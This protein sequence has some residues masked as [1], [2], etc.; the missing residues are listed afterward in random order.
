MRAHIG[1]A[2]TS[3]RALGIASAKNGLH[4]PVERLKRFHLPMLPSLRGLA[5]AG[6]DG[7]GG[8]VVV[9]GPGRVLTRVHV[10]AIFW[11]S[12][13]Y[14]RFRPGV[15]DICWAIE[16]IFLSP[17]MD[18]LSQYGV[19]NGW[20]DPNPIF[21]SMTIAAPNPFTEP[22]LRQLLGE[23]IDLPGS[24][25]SA[26]DWAGRLADLPTDPQMLPVVFTPYG[27]EFADADFNGFN[28]SMTRNGATFP[29][30]WV[31][32]DADLDFISAVYSHELAEVTTDPFG[33]GVEGP[34]GSCGQTGG[35]Q[36][37]DYCYGPQPGRGSGFLGGTGI[38]AYWSI[39]DGGCFLPQEHHVSGQPSGNLAL[40]QGRFLN[41][42]N[43][44]L[45]V[46]QQGGG[47]AHYSRCNDEARLWWY[48]PEQFG[49]ELG[50]IDAVTMIQSNFTMGSGV[51]NLEVIAHWQGELLFF[52]REDIPPYRWHG[53][54]LLNPI[55]SGQLVVA[56]GSPSLIQ[57]RFG[58]KGNFELV[59]PVASGGLAH[60][61]R[62]N[63]DPNLN[64]YGPTI[65]AR[66]AGV[67]D[68]AC[69]VQSHF[70]SSGSGAG[71]LE[72]IAKAG[73]LLLHYWRD[74]A[75]PY[76][77]HGPDAIPLGGQIPVGVPSFIQ[78]SFLPNG[79]FQVV[80]PTSSGGLAHYTRDNTPFG[81]AAW[82]GPTVFGNGYEGGPYQAVSLI[83][84]NFASDAFNLFHG[85]PGNL[86]LVARAQNVL[87]HFW[88]ADNTQISDGNNRD[89]YG[90]W[91]VS[92]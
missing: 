42:G 54:S 8:G 28:N 14:A 72:V 48:G 10:K 67:V 1:K 30:V 68:A 17:Y 86:E 32:S 71:N 5:G 62:A 77:W 47:F 35:C 81:G 22:Q 85:G 45:L 75:P 53:P 20:L 70:S 83:Q 13:W 82:N 61:S 46:P 78:D 84:S 79:Y 4:V 60:Y 49:Q 51:G 59:T 21:T 73:G 19:G 38:S 26:P 9:Q 25:G 80:T 89:W 69:L 27:V 24:A 88:R 39:R 15:G 64:W 37:A 91:V 36:I 57:S 65:F 87:F 29:Y 66:D 11:G 2:L 18:G 52:W 3:G 12:Q 43:F 7:G 50:A 63:D 41:R 74:D 34:A 23:M 16:T 90:P 55:G 92:Y 58:A 40:I 33:T 31:K 6:A 44:E 56:A 76:Q